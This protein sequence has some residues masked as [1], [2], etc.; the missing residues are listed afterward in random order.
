MSVNVSAAQIVTEQLLACLKF[1]KV[2]FGPKRGEGG[3]SGLVSG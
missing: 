2:P 1:F 3:A